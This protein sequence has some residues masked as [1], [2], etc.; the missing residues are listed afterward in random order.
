MRT[1]GRSSSVRR[2]GGRSPRGRAVAWLLVP[3]AAAAYVLTAGVPT[4]APSAPASQ[5]ADT[6]PAP[7]GEVSDDASEQPAGLVTVT[8]TEA[9]T[10]ALVQ[11]GL[12]QSQAPAL[13]DV[14]VDV[15]AP[16]GGRDG[17]MI[18]AG[19]LR[20]QPLPVRAT[21]DLEVVD[22]S[23]RPTVRTAT[24]GPFAVPA[25]V[26]GD[27]NRQLRELVVIADQNVVVHDLRT[28]DSTVVL[29]GRRR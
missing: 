21:V 14:T 9:E 3:V 4:P 19:R 28:T 22:K 10:T 16:E 18:V 1:V 15:V 20:D 6:A 2:R 8:L 25:A 7:V 29:T 26:R 27:L 17:Q 11:A 24:I 5:A 13:R 12:A 23:V